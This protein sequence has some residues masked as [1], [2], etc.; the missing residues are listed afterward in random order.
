MHLPIFDGHNDALGRF[1]PYTNDSVAEFFVRRTEGHIDLP[2]AR[3]G[4][5]AGGFFAVYA[6]AQPP[7]TPVPFEVTRTPTGYEVPLAAPLDPAHASRMS[8]AMAAGLFRLE[9]ASS[10]EIKVVR[11]VEEVARCLQTGVLAAVLHLEGADAIDPELYLLDVLYR[12]GLRSLGI[13]WS[14]PNPFGYG[15]PFR[16]PHSPDT[17]P[18]LTAEGRALV[19]ACNRLGIL[20]D[21]SH[22][23]EQGFWD[24][25]AITS[26]PI[27]AT[28]SNV[29]ALCPVTR[30]LTDRQLDAIRESD[31][32]V[33]VNFAV[34][35][36]RED[37]ENNPDTPLSAVVRQIDYLAER[38]GIDRV[39]FGSDFDGATVPLELGD[40]AG[41]PRLIAELRQAGYDEASL[42]K[43]AYENWLRVLELT[44]RTQEGTAS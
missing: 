12:A 10:G 39:G 22:L 3:E 16:F 27:V 6:P 20:V 21:V 32:M 44:W 2:R 14:R 37:G 7:G 5:L 4:G 41:L 31:G 1:Y 28:H 34:S 18:G 42:R 8:I 38:L 9:A 29:H 24:L 19:R 11:T 17:G 35:F 15:V 13:V 23:N 26:A 36:L 25:A 40:V 33:G 43:L 30:N